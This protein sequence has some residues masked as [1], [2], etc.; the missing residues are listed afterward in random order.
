MNNKHFYIGWQDEMPAPTQAFLKR[1]IIALFLLLPVLAALAVLFQKPFNDHTFEL[2]NI[3]EITGIYYDTPVPILL[4]DEGVLPDS[5]S[6]SIMLVGFGKFGAEQI[7]EDIQ[8]EAGKLSGKKVTLAGTL[9]YGDG[10]TV[11]E[12]TQKA[13][14]IVDVAPDPALP[15]PQITNGIDLVEQGEILDPKCYFGV[16]KPGEGKVHKSCAIRCLSGGI[17]PVFKQE[18]DDHTEY[19][20]VLDAK[21]NKMNERLLPYIGHMIKINGRTAQFLDW[22]ILFVDAGHLPLHLY[23]LSE[24]CSQKTPTQF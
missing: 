22:N 24:L 21:G 20:I 7:M 13:K 19:Y 14:S 5:L 11:M 18:I 17:P 15:A 12:L 2:G 6:R 8:S 9:I 16:M 3:K 1:I 4:A 23:R 10:K